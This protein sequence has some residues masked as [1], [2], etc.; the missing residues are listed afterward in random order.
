MFLRRLRRR[1]RVLSVLPAAWW[2]WK[3][4]HVL[5][6]MAGFA[7]TVPDRMKL[8][9]SG[10]VALAAKVHLALLREPRL[11]GADLR[12]GAVQ[13]GD[14]TIETGRG[15]EAE[16]EIARGVIAGIPGVTSVR[17]EDG[18]SMPA[19]SVSDGPAG[20]VDGA[21]AVDRLDDGTVSSPA[22]DDAPV[23]V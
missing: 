4:R 8:G 3:E 21:A 20:Q 5:A 16:A 22:G 18:S 11:K 1:F 10:E 7:R 9:R 19:P 15:S 13:G 12:L 2:V 14:V 6:G 23:R 17:V